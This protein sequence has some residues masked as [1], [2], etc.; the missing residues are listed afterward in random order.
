MSTLTEFLSE[1]HYPLEISNHFLTG[2]GADFL[3]ARA[4][5]SRFMLLGEEHGVGSNLE[6]ATALFKA[7]QPLGYTTYVTEIGPFSAAHFNRL[8]KQ[9]DAMAAFEAFYRQ[10][11]FSVPFAWLREEVQLYQAVRAGS[12]QE[13]PIIGIDQEFILS[14]QWHLE[15]L[16]NVCD[17]PGWREKLSAWLEIE[18]QANHALASGTTPDQLTCFMNLPLPDDWDALR[19]HFSST[20]N[21]DAVA[22]M[23]A[24]QA[25]HQI[26]MHYA[27]KEYYDN[28]HVRGKLMR[29]YF[30]DA[31]KNAQS[32][33]RFFVKLGA[34]HVSRGHTTMGILDVGNFIAELAHIEDT[35][36]FHLLVLPVSGTLNAW[37]PFLPE[38]FKA[39]PIEGNYGPEFT[40]LLE[41]APVKTGWNLYDLRP[42][43]LRQMH[44]SK[45][46]PAFKDLDPSPIS[47]ALADVT[48]LRSYFRRR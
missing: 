2:P 20:G 25:S 4:Q 38:S 39:H 30:Y 17:D 15:T 40:P 37:F 33:D 10:Y 45:D 24:L 35:Q 12:S 36:S 22:R 8:V 48:R 1:H 42:L 41:A 28:N 29:K 7:I 47:P 34:N 3:H 32:D 5:E 16:L 19:Q 18:R 21:S 26:Y 43:R 27:N 14:P 23:D 11:P 6:F 13:T 31:Y 44:W 9:P 46:N